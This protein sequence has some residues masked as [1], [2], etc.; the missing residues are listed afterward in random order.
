[1]CCEEIEE[2]LQC[3]MLW[4]NP[5]IYPKQ[6][7]TVQRIRKP[8]EPN[9]GDW[10]VRIPAVDADGSAIEMMHSHVFLPYV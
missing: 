3:K 2:G 6:I 5:E 10:F 1:M 4:L 7:G 8:K 9:G